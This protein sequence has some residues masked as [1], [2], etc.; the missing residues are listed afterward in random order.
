M[1]EPRKKPWKTTA[2]LIY[3]CVSNLITQGEDFIP[4]WDNTDHLNFVCEECHAKAT[5]LAVEFFPNIN[6]V[7]ATLYFRLKCPSCKRTGQR[8]IYLETKDAPFQQA[9]DY[10][11]QLLLYTRDKQKPVKIIQLKQV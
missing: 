3:Q 2:R 9:L 6:E 1:N 4:T 8:K 7:G 10:S 5:I 11:N